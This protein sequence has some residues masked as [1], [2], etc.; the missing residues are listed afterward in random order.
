M[1]HQSWGSKRK[2]EVRGNVIK[3]FR[4]VT[5]LHSIPADRTCLALCGKQ[6]NKPGFQV[7]QY[8][9]S[10]F[11]KPGQYIGVD[12]EQDIVEFN[13]QQHP[14]EKFIE[15]EWNHLFPELLSRRPMLIDLDTTSDALTGE[16][17]RWV[18]SALCL[19]KPGTFVA[20]N[21]SMKNVYR[22]NA[23]KVTIEQV[24]TQ[25]AKYVPGRI[26]EKWE[27]VG[28]FSSITRRAPMRTF[29][30]YRPEAQLAA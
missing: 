15:G 12:R 29:L 18:A 23:P 4:K 26:L 16:A 17:L 30:F 27:P 25:I 9:E 5:G 6:E 1:P 28:S 13:Q 19:A 8:V 3:A 10:G 11:I 14:Q 2:S 20:Y 24:T 7:H 21:V 22:P